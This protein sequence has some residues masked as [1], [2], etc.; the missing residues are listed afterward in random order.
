MAHHSLAPGKKQML[1]VTSAAGAQIA[2]TVT[3]PNGDTKH[4]SGTA[5]SAGTFVFSYKQPG[6][7]ITHNSS[8]ASVSALATLGAQSKHSVKTYAIGFAQVDVSSLPRNQHAGKSISIWIHASRGTKYV[9]LKL[10]AHKRIL[11]TTSG[12]VG[13]HGWWYHH[14]VIP[15]KASKG[16]VGVYGYAVFKSGKTYRGETSFRI[17]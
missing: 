6:S 7:R 16:R 14:Y 2:V 12:Y 3:F 17:D 4:A 9:G 15:K 8:K 11:A 13:K 1:T 10:Y 5:S